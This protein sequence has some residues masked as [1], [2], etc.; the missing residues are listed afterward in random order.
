MVSLI[1]YG[2]DKL[3][4]VYG[5]GKVDPTNGKVIGYQISHNEIRTLLTDLKQ[6]LVAL[7]VY[8]VL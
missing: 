4:R 5:H 6:A 7:E 3:I 2:I 8:Q 1:R